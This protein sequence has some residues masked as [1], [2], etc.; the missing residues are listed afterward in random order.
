VVAAVVTA[1]AVVTVVFLHT[2]ADAARQDQVRVEQIASA[3]DSLATVPLVA[4]YASFGQGEQLLKGS[5]STIKAQLALL[6]QAGP[7]RQLATIRV[8]SDAYESGLSR[9][10]PL[11]HLL[12]Q[13]SGNRVGLLSALRLV[14]SYARE[15]RRL[16]GEIRTLKAA[17]AGAER[18][19]AAA[20]H[21]RNNEA[22]VGSVLAVLLSCLGFSAVFRSLSRSRTVAQALAAENARLLV[23]SRAEAETDALTGL[24]NRRKL[25]VDL[26]DALE[27]RAVGHRVMLGLFDL[28]G[29][30]DANDTFGHPA[31]DRLLERLSAA[32]AAAAA[33]DATAYRMGGDE[34]C[35]IR[36]GV[37]FDP[38]ETLTKCRAALTLSEIGISISSSY[39]SVLIPDEADTV[40]DALRV[41]DQ[42]L[43]AAKA[44][45]RAAIGLSTPPVRPTATV[46]SLRV[47]MAQ[48]VASEGS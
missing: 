5:A 20:A 40:E 25:M 30:K 22:Y 6:P 46:T 21:A 26:Q 12:E 11:L 1:A 32:L 4:L 45:S 15:Q 29:F 33:P 41:A 43:Y 17:T 48:L 3:S 23:R 36:S 27:K 37:E 10:L 44:L 38:D 24:S 2:R 19:Y 8:S 47:P 16:V 13:R 14:P 18:F 34:F 42:R 35:V 39:G 28:D 9:V 7:S 31:G